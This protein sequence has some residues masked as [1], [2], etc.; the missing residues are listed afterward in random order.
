MAIFNSYVKLPEG[1]FLGIFQQDMRENIQR[2]KTMFGQIPQRGLLDIAHA[3]LVLAD[4]KGHRSNE[5]CGARWVDSMLQIQHLELVPFRWF[6]ISMFST[7]VFTLSSL[8]VG[9]WLVKSP[10]GGEI[11][12]VS[13]CPTFPNDRSNLFQH[14]HPTQKPKRKRCQSARFNPRLLH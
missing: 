7:P 12:A 1:T 13:T 14:M 5:E 11:Q 4:K 3:Q 10:Y 2:V 9:F 8:S 6:F